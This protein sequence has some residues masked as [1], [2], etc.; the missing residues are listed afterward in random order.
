[1]I[2]NNLET[3]RLSNTEFYLQKEPLRSPNR[4]LFQHGITITIDEAIINN[5]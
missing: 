2:P 4:V 1:M 3:P 5:S